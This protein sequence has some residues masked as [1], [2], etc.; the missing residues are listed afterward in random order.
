MV[1]DEVRCAYVHVSAHVARALLVIIGTR[2]TFVFNPSPTGNP[3]KIL[4]RGVM[5]QTCIAK[6]SLW[7]QDGNVVG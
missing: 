7:L 3:E 1:G 2:G 5:N 4:Y 6:G